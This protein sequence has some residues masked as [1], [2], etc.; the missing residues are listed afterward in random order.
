VIDL[1]GPILAALFGV[2]V[3]AV[4]AKLWPRRR[5][6]VL[7]SGHLPAETEAARH[8]PPGLRAAF[9]EIDRDLGIVDLRTA[10]APPTAA[11]PDNPAVVERSWALKA[12]PTLATYFEAGITAGEFARKKALVEVWNR[13]TAAEVL[14]LTHERDEALRQVAELER[15][16]RA[17]LGKFRDRDSEVRALRSQVKHMGEKIDRLEE[18][19]DAIAS[20]SWRRL[21]ELQELRPGASHPH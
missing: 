1:L 7:L 21:C 12:E 19:R 5:R 3:V 16:E 8:P 14:R 17:V 11:D 6:R 4:A 9:E 15:R 10:P 20:E 2:L 18:E 13:V